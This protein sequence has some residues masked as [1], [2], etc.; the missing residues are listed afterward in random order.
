MRKLAL[1]ALDLPEGCER[2][3]NVSLE[4]GESQYFHFVLNFHFDIQIITGVNS[5]I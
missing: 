3:D 4:H 2:A 5:S 1:V